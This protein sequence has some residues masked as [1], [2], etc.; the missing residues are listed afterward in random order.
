MGICAHP[1]HAIRLSGCRDVLSHRLWQWATA[2]SVVVNPQCYIAGELTVIDVVQIS[3]M[4]LAVEPDEIL[5]IA[6][7]CRNIV[8]EL[9]NRQ[10]QCARF[11]VV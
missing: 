7:I 9:A 3:I 4:Y 1:R 8:W 6:K 5:A 11:C 2:N 10:T